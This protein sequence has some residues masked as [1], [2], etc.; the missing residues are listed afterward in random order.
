VEY[1][2]RYVYAVGCSGVQPARIN[3][4]ENALK[5]PC[6]ELIAW[7]AQMFGIQPKDIAEGVKK[8]VT[9][10]PVHNVCPVHPSVNKARRFGSLWDSRFWGLVF[11]H[12]ELVS[13]DFPNAVFLA[14]YW[15]DLQAGSCGK[16]VIQAGEEIR[17]S[18]DCDQRA[19]SH[20]W[21]SPNIFAPYQTE[22]L[23]DLE[24]GS[25][26]NDWLEGM[27]KELA[28]L[29]AHYGGSSATESPEP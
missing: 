15:W 24:F 14:E 1:E 26:W 12:V 25:L 28:A 20:E 7:R 4:I 8:T 11:S 22:Y 19:Q 16:I 10:N 27:R 3:A 29:T 18:H 2:Y 21:V 17:S 13:Q 9:F 23:L 6:G 5:N